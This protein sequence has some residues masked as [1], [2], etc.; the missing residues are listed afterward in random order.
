MGAGSMMI[1][2]FGDVSATPVA[3]SQAATSEMILTSVV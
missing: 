3:S 1:M 2:S